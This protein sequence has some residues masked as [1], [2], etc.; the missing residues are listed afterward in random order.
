MAMS[1]YINILAQII[2]CKL[3]GVKIESYIK[4]KN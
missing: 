1:L 2:D 3:A 4:A